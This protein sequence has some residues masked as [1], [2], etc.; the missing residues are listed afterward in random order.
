MTLN[1]RLRQMKTYVRYRTAL[2][3]QAV[4]CLWDTN[5]TKLSYYSL[6][7]TSNNIRLFIAFN[8]GRGL[9]VFERVFGLLM[10]LYITG[11]NYISGTR[12]IRSFIQ[13][14]ALLQGRD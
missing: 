13:M 9:I 10:P 11:M 5:S 1:N 7:V 6:I 8:S 12:V 14:H 2:I 3:C 4:L